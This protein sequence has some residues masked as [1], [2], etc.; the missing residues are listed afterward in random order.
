MIFEN[1]LN[2]TEIVLNNNVK[3]LFSYK[4]PV[5]YIDDQSNRLHY[6]T[7]HYWSKTTTSHIN[8]W[9]SLN[10][11][12]KDDAISINQSGLDNLTK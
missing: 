10:G 7:S 1:T 11:L 6:K 2:M 8:K 5:A 9:F 3:V 4:T 12:N